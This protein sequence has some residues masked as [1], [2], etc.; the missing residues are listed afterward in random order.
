MCTGHLLLR[1]A[2]MPGFNNF[3][4]IGLDKKTVVYTNFST[5]CRHLN[6]C[7]GIIL[8]ANCYDLYANLFC[9]CQR[10][11]VIFSFRHQKR[12]ILLV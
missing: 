4:G 5:G 11:R 8:E 1:A 3:S 2:H 12:L 10:A 6:A 9:F 7:A